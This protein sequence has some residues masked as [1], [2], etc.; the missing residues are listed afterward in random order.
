MD[1]VLNNLQ[2]L[3]CHK[4]QQTKPNQSGNDTVTQCYLLLYK[5]NRSIMVK[6]FS[7]CILRLL[8]KLELLW[9]PFG[10]WGSKAL[11]NCLT[12]IYIYIYI[13]IKKN[14]NRSH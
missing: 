9:E 6:C 4:T 5:L 10:A 3:I 7:Y 8:K 13:Y 1:L 12:D 2:R 11:P 14:N